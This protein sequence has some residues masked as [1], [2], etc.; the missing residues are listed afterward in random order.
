MYIALDNCFKYIYLGFLCMAPFI[1]N[2]NKIIALKNLN[3]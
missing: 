2:I 3:D 1:R